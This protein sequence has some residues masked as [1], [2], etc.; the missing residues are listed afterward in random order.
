[1]EL[2]GEVVVL[3]LA[4]SAAKVFVWSEINRRI[5]RQV[6]KPSLH[7][8]ALR[9]GSHV[10]AFAI[11]HHSTWAIGLHAPISK[12]PSFAGIC[13]LVWIYVWNYEGFDRG[14]HRVSG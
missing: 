14:T 9:R 5:L 3:K 4:P 13:L 8:Y 7:L 10:H 1:M 11:H 12:H 6:G 2:E